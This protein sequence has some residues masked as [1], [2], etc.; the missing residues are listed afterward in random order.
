MLSASEIRGMYAI[1][2]SPAKVGAEELLATA[3]V[4]LDETER[5]VNALISDGCNGLI[6]L[7]TTGECAT[8]SLADYQAFVSCFV[9]T[10][11]KRVPTFIGATGLGGHDIALRLKLLEECGADGAMLG[12]P[13]WQPLT[14]ESAVK[15]YVEVSRAFPELAI[16]V[17]ANQ[18]AFR[19]PFTE[20]DE[21]WSE[22]VAHAPTVVAAKVSKP[23]SLSALLKTV[24]DR[25]NIMPNEMNLVQ[26]YEESPGTTTACWATAASM[27]PKPILELMGAVQRNDHEAMTKL[28]ATLA[29]ANEPIAS[30]V[31]NPEQFALYTIQMEKARIKAAGYCNPGPVRPPYDWMPETLR[32]DSEECGRRWAQ[33]NNFMSSGASI[34]DFLA[35]V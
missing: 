22:L 29:W 27:G 28:S 14:T 30:L 21:F 8:L 34:Y 11:G 31:S 17:Y 3:T 7:G 16:M 32:R 4:D 15:F 35:P 2:P 5:M 23:R 18:R 10:V 13:M 9:E 25:V 24:G 19:F 12:L 1:T 6:A 33:L 26:F 20:T